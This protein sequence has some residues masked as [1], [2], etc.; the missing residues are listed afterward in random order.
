[1]EDKGGQGWGLADHGIGWGGGGKWEGRDDAYFL[2]FGKVL[3][4]LAGNTRLERDQV[5]S[6]VGILYTSDATLFFRCDFL[7]CSMEISLLILSLFAKRAFHVAGFIVGALQTIRS[8]ML[9]V[10]PAIF[11]WNSEYGLSWP[12]PLS[13]KHLSKAEPWDYR[14]S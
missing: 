13:S 14:S 4:R 6:S 9:M 12:C 11:Y 8:I 1:M 2:A 7:H 5:V 10:D 3:R